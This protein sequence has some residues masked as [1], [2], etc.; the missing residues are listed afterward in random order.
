[1]NRKHCVF[2]AVRIWSEAGLRL[3]FKT[4]ARL[5]YMLHNP[6]K[7]SIKHKGI[8]FIPSI[9]YVFLT[10]L[11]KSHVRAIE[12]HEL[13]SLRNGQEYCLY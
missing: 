4:Y 11:F 10:L 13:V 9:I 7:Q 8:V 5:P 3:R 1:M 2:A 12:I 6:K